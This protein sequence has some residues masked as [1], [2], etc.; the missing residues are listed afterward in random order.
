MSDMD[1]MAINDPIGD[2]HLRMIL[3]SG[4]ASVVYDLV[5]SNFTGANTNGLVGCGNQWITPSYQTYPT[6]PFL[7]DELEITHVVEE[8]E[9]LVGYTE[10]GTKVLLGDWVPTA[11]SLRVRSLLERIAAGE[12]LED[13]DL[14]KFAYLKRLLDLQQEE[15]DLTSKRIEFIEKLIASS[16]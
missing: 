4:E 6:M 13:S 8:E 16:F 12:E 14:E 10:D 11:V 7:A 5:A 9:G 2:D 3:A 15:L 1:D